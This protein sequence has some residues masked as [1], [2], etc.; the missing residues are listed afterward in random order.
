MKKCPYP[1]LIVLV[2]FSG[3]SFRFLSPIIVVK[4]N[5]SQSRCPRTGW[6]SDILLERYPRTAECT[7]RTSTLQV[8]RYPTRI[9]TSL[10]VLTNEATVVSRRSRNHSW[11][12]AN[13]SYDYTGES[14]L[15]VVYWKRE[16]RCEVSRVSFGTNR[17]LCTI[18]WNTFRNTGDIYSWKI[19]VYSLWNITYL[20]WS[21]FSRRNVSPYVVRCNVNRKKLISVCS[22]QKWLTSRNG[23]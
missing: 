7:A 14:K 1:L 12:I 18:E 3:T 6:K 22:T 21:T 17:I 11:I 20:W 8:Q 4:R 13:A 5:K 16:N 10:G 9:C 23:I 15:P 2:S 19:E